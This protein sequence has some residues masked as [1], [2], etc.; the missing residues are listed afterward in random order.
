MPDP[1]FLRAAASLG[2]R[3]CREA[4]WD[5][6]RCNWMGDAQ[7]AV[8]GQLA[9]VHRA[10][11]PVLYDG[12]AGIGLF[13]AR[14]F[15]ATG[16]RPFRTA[17]LG[18]L[19]QSLRAKDRVG[20]ELRIALHAGWTGMAWAL[21]EA[22]DTLG[23][24]EWRAESAR[25]AAEL[26]GIDPHPLAVDVISGSAGAIPVLLELARRHGDDGLMENAVRH[27]EFLL[28]GARRGNDGWSWHTMD[29]PMRAPLTG[30]SHGAAGVALALL[31]LAAATGDERFRAA[32]DEGFRY[33]AR[34]FSPEHGNWP[35][36]RLFGDP[37][38]AAAQPVSYAVAWCHG[39]PGIGLSRLRAYELTGDAD[40]RMEAEAALA[41]T[42]RTLDAAVATGAGFGFSLCHGDA[43]NAELPLLAARVLGDASQA[44]RAARVGRM[45][46]ERYLATGAPWPCGVPGG[47]ETPNLMLGLAGIGW[48][49][50]RLHDPSVPSVLLVHPRAACPALPWPAE[51]A[52]NHFHAEGA[53]AAEYFIARRNSSAAPAPSA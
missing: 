14:L 8:N 40:R 36:F 53:E 2:A 33:E 13:L 6:D 12:T 50:L 25:L 16:E 9:V 3:L 15:A 17:A 27:G 39:A 43:G 23:E 7:D 10:Q 44:E 18:A 5:G 42:A 41:T 37:A 19:R 28:D 29:A 11:T 35:D 4:V 30:Y 24:D 26:R 20:A 48:F 22:A 52:K 47:G 45:G 49:Y 38:A 31:E 1:A 21:A 46:M 32:A 51:K 34:W